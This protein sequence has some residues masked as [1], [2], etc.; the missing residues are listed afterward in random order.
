M[1]TIDIVRRRRARARR[2]N[3]LGPRAGRVLALA[4]LLLALAA[5]FAPAAAL[6]G[7]A[8]GLLAFVRDLPDVESL[9]DLPAA[10]A[11]SPLTTRLYAYDAPGADGLRHPV[12]IDEI[13]DPRAGGAGWLPLSQLPPAVISATLAAVD[14]GYFARPPLDVVAAAGEWRRTGAVTQEVSPL[15]ANLVDQYLSRPA[16]ERGA[17]QRFFL[18]WQI[19]RRFGRQWALETTLNTT[20]YGHLAYGIEA[21]ARLYFGAGAAELTTAQAALLA[22]VARDPAANPF[23]APDAAQAGQTTILDAMEHAG[24][25]S[26]QAAAGARGQPLHLAA[27]P[28][29][30]AA[31]PAFA[32][33]AR[34][35]LERTLGP[36]PLARGGYQ[37]ET[38]LDLALQAPAECLAAAAT[39]RGAPLGG[40]PPCAAA[41]ALPSVPRADAVAVVVMAPDSGALLALAGDDPLAARPSGTLARPFI[42]LSAL[43]QGYTAASLTYDVERIYLE[44][45]RPYVPPAEGDYR[46]P[47]RLREALAADRAAPAAQMLGWV[48]VARVLD[49]A[50]ALGV[51]VAGATPGLAFAQEGF[52]ADPLSLAHAFAAI[53]NGGALA[54]A[55][56]ADAPRPAT[57]VRV[58]DRRGQEVYALAPATRDALSPELAW[59]M[60]DMLRA[61]DAGGAALATGRT[62]AGDAW[63]I[64]QS[65]RRL[66]AVWAGGKGGAATAVDLWRPLFDLAS[67]GQPAGEWPQPPGL[68]AVDVCAL[69]GL[70]PRREGPDCPTVR[71]WFVAGTE[72]TAPD[73]MTREVAVNRETGRLATYFTPPALVE[74]RVFTVY[75][76]EAAVWAAE[77][78]VPAPP[79]EYDTI[80]RVPTRQGDAAMTAPEPWSTGSGQW[81]VVGSAGGEGFAY[82]R[83]A[84][85]PGLLP[86][87]LELIV[88]RG[89][90]AVSGGELGVWDTGALADGLYTL[91]L[92]V[93][94][95]DGTFDEVA[96]PVL[97]GVSQ[98]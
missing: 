56:G 65:P 34:A 98:P 40:G 54:G 5:V 46:G 26:P 77:A 7:G 83:L 76:P 15:L 60:T 33:L 25:L 53:G 39:G 58:L 92:T 80:R 10:Y 38:T 45:G 88:E 96:I 90:T 44:D 20:Y 64:G 11:P 81:P 19:E 14:P 21:A 12:L 4:V 71:E 3:G 41:D 29:A 84:Y 18:A 32:R 23:D 79:A 35:E 42:A 31:A 52:T 97:V 61:A 49:N 75:P 67:A 2:A 70:L 17:R 37:V 91:L 1:R 85:F 30:A 63:A 94:H 16:T 9:R 66:V 43:S 28:W 27:P 73:T 51:D 55:P 36:E 8:A 82:Y 57:V 13:A 95:N 72:P 87:K 59:L 69:S 6:A 86:D 78:G 24:L 22:A 74:R 50:R 93:V 89:E 47:L 48:G 62:A 68:R